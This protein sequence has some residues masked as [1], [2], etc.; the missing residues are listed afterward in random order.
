MT[1]ILAI[2]GGPEKSG[3]VWLRDG[4]PWQWGWLDNEDLREELFDWRINYDA[5]LVIEDVSHYGKNISVGNDVFQMVR[6]T[7]RF[8]EAWGGSTTYIKRPTIKTAICGVA[9]AKDKDVR[10]AL[11]DRFGGDAIAIGGKKCGTCHGK[12]LRGRGK[13]KGACP[14]CHCVG[15]Y[16]PRPGLL[17]RGCGY[18]SHPGPLHGITSHCWSALAVG[19]TY[20][21]QKEEAK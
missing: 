13:A 6:W 5:H 15:I 9:S 11:I 18:E 3:Y 14:D 10:Q 16:L 2:D 19:V 8:E 12:G 20:L 1:N 17:N 7:G 4:V 21:A